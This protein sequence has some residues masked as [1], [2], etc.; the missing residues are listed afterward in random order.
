VQALAAA[1]AW[2][3]RALK[4]PVARVVPALSAKEVACEPLHVNLLDHP[5]LAERYFFRSPSPPR[6]AGSGRWP[7]RSAAALDIV[8]QGANGD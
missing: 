2:L 6:S 3:A 4:A 5:V 1:L 8:G 7:R